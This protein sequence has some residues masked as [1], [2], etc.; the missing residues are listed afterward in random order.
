[1]EENELYVQD[2]SGSC[3]FPDYSSGTK[4]YEIEISD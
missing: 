1:L 4:R 2:L 3:T